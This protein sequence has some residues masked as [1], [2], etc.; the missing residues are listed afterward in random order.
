MKDTD[1]LLLKLAD[2]EARAKVIREQLGI[3]EETPIADA[4][5]DLSGCWFCRLMKWFRS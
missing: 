1:R 2:C 3:A 4:A 5:I